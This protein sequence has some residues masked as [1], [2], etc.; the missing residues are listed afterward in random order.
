[1]GKLF[2][3]YSENE[4]LTN[5]RIKVTHLYFFPLSFV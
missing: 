2:F 3:P 1:L 4:K 5:P